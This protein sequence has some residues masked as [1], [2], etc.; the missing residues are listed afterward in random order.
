MDATGVEE[1]DIELVCKQSN[2][3]RKRAI[4]ALISNA[5]DIVSA[6]MVSALHNVKSLCWMIVFT[7]KF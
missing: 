3:S 1:K 5:N 6:I 7:V 4:E 2:V